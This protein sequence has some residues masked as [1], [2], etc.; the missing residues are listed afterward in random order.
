MVQHTGHS[1][2]ANSTKIYDAFTVLWGFDRVGAFEL[3]F[4]CWNFSK[5]V[6]EISE[7]LFLVEPTGDNNHRVVWLIVFFVKGAE[8]W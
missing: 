7:C 3:T 8:A 2:L 4:R 1:Y 5:V 6:V